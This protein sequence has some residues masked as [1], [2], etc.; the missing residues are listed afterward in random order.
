MHRQ[1][2][3]ACTGKGV[4]V[5][6]RSNFH[7][8]DI[9]IIR[10]TLLMLVAASLCRVSAETYYISPSGD[11]ANSGKSTVLAWKTLGMVN[12]R[13][14]KP[15]DSVLFQGGETFNGNLYLDQSDGN[16]KDNPL[17][18]SSYGGKAATLNAGDGF[19]ISAYNTQGI[20]IS[21]LNIVGSGM[22][23]NTKN[24]LEWYVDVPGDK[25][26]V[27]IVLERIEVRGFGRV[28]VRIGAWN[29]NTGYDG[30]ILQDLVVHDNL[31]DGILV[32]G[33]PSTNGYPN[34]D[35]VIRGCASYR[36]PGI[37]DPKSIKGNGIVISNTDGAVIEYC[38]AYENGQANVHCGGPG[39]IWAYDANRIVI[40]Y[41][42]SYA[43]KTSSTCDGLGFD[44]DGGVTNSIIQYCYSHDNAGGGY[45]LG[46]YA[47]ARPWRNNICRYNISV[48]DGRT[49]ASGITLFKGS[50]ESIMDGAL[51]HNNTIYSKP[52]AANPS[53]A[54]FQITEWNTGMQNIGVYNNVFVAV[55][56]VPLIS[57]PAKYSAFFAGNLYWTDGSPFTINYQGKSYNSLEAWRG[58]TD[59]ELL[60]G[61]ATG[62]VIDP[63]LTR[64][65]AAPTTWPRAVSSLDAYRAQVGSPT[66][67][68]GVN[69]SGSLG[70]DQGDR[71]FYGVVVPS[72]N[73]YDIGA[74]EYSPTDTARNRPPV[75]LQLRD[76]S[77]AM[78]TI[79]DVP[80]RVK[81]ESPYRLQ[82]G[83]TVPTSSLFPNG[84]AR[85]FGSG[86]IQTLRLQPAAG[87]TG[88]AEMTVSATDDWGLTSIQRVRVT[89]GS[90]TSVEIVDDA[91]FIIR[92]TPD[93]SVARVEVRGHQTGTFT[94][95]VISMSSGEVVMSNGINGVTSC[96]VIELPL[97]ELASG[98]YIIRA[99]NGRSASS[100]HFVICR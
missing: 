28:G 85:L 63:R 40:Q 52:T 68:N 18:I 25:R 13:D 57:V 79:I 90:A 86:P 34:K 29:G 17:V 43:N 71:D 94:C 21:D 92:V 64:M 96:H 89:V 81:D 19:G 49:N 88:V 76:T 55:G 6:S 72:R 36:N 20:H 99:T 1:R 42:E 61:I 93:A 75:I 48:N 91:P 51:I 60:K 69:L 2:G 41:C 14:L 32:Y 22:N 54:T 73:G 100:E 24:G 31:H 16:A 26:F 27:D 30:L 53:H 35:V 44:L 87:Q 80:F 15:G 45:L 66:I 9:M 59:N 74:H 23:T 95:D 98:A 70:I 67:D 77:M 4:K 50:P 7:H 46:Q 78:S 33:F 8:G 47:N 97:H 84:S 58:A 3:E 39:G 12:S 82:C 38:V 5:D 62:L 10:F 83:L 65:G 56:G 11:D 37:A